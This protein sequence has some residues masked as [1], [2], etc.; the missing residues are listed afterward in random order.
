M[1]L[2][3]K[4]HPACIF[5]EYIQH[6]AGT[7]CIIIESPVQNSDVFYPVSTY[8]F[9]SIPDLLYALVSYGL[10]A[11]AYTECASVE[12][13]A[14]GFKLDER[15]VPIEEAALLGIFQCCKIRYSRYAIVLVFSC[16][17]I[18][19]AQTVDSLPVFF[20]FYSFQPLRQ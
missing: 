8:I 19:P 1:N 20:L 12:A 11:T 5:G 7:G 15:L 18:Q 14:C 17:G 10:F 13:S 3:M 16:L 4:T 9:K 2:Q 6:F